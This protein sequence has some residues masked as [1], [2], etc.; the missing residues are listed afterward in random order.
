MRKNNKKGFTLIE[1]IVVLVII[2]ILLALAVPAVFSYVKKAADTKLISQARSVMV[3]SKEKGIQLVKKQQLYLLST[4]DNMDDII[5]MSEIDGTLIEIHKNRTEDGAGDFIVKID[6][7]Y[8]RYDDAEQ[9]YEIL[10]DYDGVFVKANAIVAAL[11]KG[12]AASEVNNYFS[13]KS[14]ATLNSE[15]ANKG[16]AIRQILESSGIVKDDNYSFRIYKRKSENIYTI[17]VSERRITMDDYHNKTKVKVIQYSYNGNDGFTGTPVIKTAQ[18]GIRKG[19]DSD[20]SQK[21]Y[22]ALDLANIPDSEWEIIKD[23]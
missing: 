9:R 20:V 10:E 1:I 16:Q 6:D 11:T 7:A 8:I 23:K 5:K 22:P 19:E 2:G 17:T 18:A 13:G 3:A 21:P 12:S 15:G 4:Q 14:D